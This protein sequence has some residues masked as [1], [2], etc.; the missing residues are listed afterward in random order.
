VVFV[1]IT[2]TFAYSTAR[3]VNESRAGKMQVGTNLATD[4]GAFVQDATAVWKFSFL[5]QTPRMDALRT[6]SDQP[7]LFIPTRPE[8]DRDPGYVQYAVQ[9]GAW[10]MAPSENLAKGIDASHYQGAINWDLVVADGIVFG[11][12]KATDGNAFIDPT[13]DTNWT[14]MRRAGVIRGA[15]HFFRPLTDPVEQAEHYLSIVGDLLHYTDLPPVLDVEAYPS[16]VYQQWH[17]LPLEERKRRVRKWLVT[18]RGYVGRWPM[19]YTNQGTWQLTLGDTD[20]F[21]NY[22]LWVANYGTDQP[23]VPANN[24]GGKGWRFWQHT[25]QG[26]VNGIGGYVDLDVYK[27]IPTQLR[28]WMRIK[29]MRPLPPDI[30][31]AEMLSAFHRAS[32]ALGEDLFA[33]LDRA[34]LSYI[35]STGNL[36]RPYDG[37]AVEELPLTR[38]ERETLKDAL[39]KSGIFPAPPIEELTNQEMINIFYEAAHRLEIPGWSLLQRAGLIDLLE[40]R[41]VIYTGPSIHQLPGLDIKEKQTL[42]EVISEKFPSGQNKETYPGLTNQDVINAFYQVGKIHEISY[43]TLIKKA[44]LI[45]I[46]DD[47]QAQYSGPKVEDLSTLN[48]AEKNSLR[49]ALRLD[50]PVLKRE[51]TYPG[52]VNQDMVNLFYRT[53]KRFNQS[54]WIWLQKAK[55]EG[56]VES[57]E[58]RYQPYRGPLVGEFIGLSESEKSALQ[59][60]IDELKIG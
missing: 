39:T 19:I 7:I 29:E 50:D 9:P 56:I 42:L 27:S 13:F 47:R 40:D 17:T 28:K 25:N 54:G 53:A 31:N 46:A 5:S 58:I 60:A 16:E 12:I 38:T 22:P 49:L 32:E 20:D 33:F 21:I 10:F 8:D 26:I 55:L 4:M 48:D 37:P 23:R 1:L 59:R 18:V 6:P 15:Y 34:G 41:G 45:S 51:V 24:W 14:G 44:G 52:L 57:R 35:T 43:W 11:I 3:D 30:I 2:I 36:S